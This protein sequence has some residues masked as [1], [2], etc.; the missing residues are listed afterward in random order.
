VLLDGIGWSRRKTVADRDGLPVDVLGNLL[1]WPAVERVWLPEWLHHRDETVARL[2]AA[3]SEAK[4]RPAEPVVEP[5][6]SVMVKPV[7]A[8]ESVP[9]IP[10]LKSVAAPAAPPRRKQHPNIRVFSG[11]TPRVAGD[12][13]RLDELGN[14]W[15]KDQVTKVIREIIDTEAPIHRDRLAKL[16]A[17]AFGLGRVN[18]DRRRAI[19]HI[20]PAEYRRTDDAEFYWPVDIEPAAWKLV[21]Q[22][23]SGA[24]RVLDEVSLVEI[25]NAMVIVAEQ[26]GGVEREEI[27]REALTLF[28]GKRVTQAIGARLE[29]A[30]Q[31]ALEVGVLKQSSAGLVVIS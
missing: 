31:R 5:A 26:T 24:G 20:V 11:W 10:A 28:G 9:S 19:Q 29:A 8:Q 23:T 27:K 13:S 30:L 14:S 15:A 18:D 2:R 6:A 17:G 7:D 16:V 22:P 4:Q 12:K 3:V 21:R 25:G 1:R